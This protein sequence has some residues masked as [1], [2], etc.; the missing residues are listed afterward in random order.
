MSNFLE[1]DMLFNKLI[2]IVNKLKELEIRIM[3]LESVKTIGVKAI[4]GREGGYEVPT[5]NDSINLPV[6]STNSTP[7]TL[8]G[9]Q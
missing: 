5:D 1:T 8:N 4:G 3:K 7:T 6:R 9:F 2:E